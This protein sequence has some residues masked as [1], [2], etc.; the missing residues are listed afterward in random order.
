MSMLLRIDA[1]A[2]LDAAGTAISPGSI[3][4]RAQHATP[5]PNFPAF[6]GDWRTLAVGTPESV[7]AHPQAP[8]AT[9][10]DRRGCVLIPGLINAHTHL[11]LTHIGP[12]P[13]EPDQGFLGFV[14]TVLSN[15]HADADAISASVNAGA[16][17]ALRGGVVAV[18][19]IAGVASGKPTLAP[20]TALART[21]L[22]GV[23]YTEFFALGNHQRE[24]LA[25]LA[26]CLR[27]QRQESRLR[28]GISPHATYTVTPDAYSAA[29]SQG[30]LPVCTHAAE[31]R[32]EADFVARAA[33]P[34]RAFHERT[35]AWNDSLLQ[36][37]GQGRSPIEHLAPLLHDRPMLIAHANQCSG[38]DLAILAR[39]RSSIVYCPRSSHYFRNHERFGPHRYRDMLDAGINVCLGTDSVVNLPADSD[40]LSPL[41]EARF[42]F[43][44]DAADPLLLLSMMTTRA[45]RALGLREHAFTFR[46]TRP[47]GLVAVPIDPERS[48]PLAALLSSAAPPELLAIATEPLLP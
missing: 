41:D 3:L 25:A 39:S 13:Y 29:F 5:L 28:L 43:A 34:F 21:P 46:D 45:A 27:Q 12:R 30:S 37:F 4:L 22:H 6:A 1:H 36:V 19:D 42:L 33:G 16:T 32:E 14:R 31:N 47:A 48:D 18:G 9:R 44:R 24:N 7:E 23:S 15:R 26:R 2:I 20:F 8:E 35:G 11:D 40:R 38:E 17:Q 10:L